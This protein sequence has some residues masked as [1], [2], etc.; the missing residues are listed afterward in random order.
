[1]KS[2]KLVAAASLLAAAVWMAWPAPGSKPGGD[3]TQDLPASDKHANH[4]P[5]VTGNTRFATRPADPAGAPQAVNTSQDASRQD[6]IGKLQELAVTYDPAQLPVIRPYLMNADPAIRAA[7]VNA[8]VILG[9]AAAAPMLRDAARL[10]AS[11]DE[12]KTCLRQAAYLE[13]PPVSS[14]ELAAKADGTATK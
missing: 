1:M 12:A 9:D 13:L 7:A 6:V 2:F 11:P 14:E 3:R 4:V 8:M 5:P 10:L